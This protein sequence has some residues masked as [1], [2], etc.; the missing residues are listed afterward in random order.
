MGGRGLRGADGPR[1]LPARPE[2]LRR[3]EAGP[4]PRSPPESRGRGGAALLE[5]AGPVLPPHGPIPRRSRAR[6]CHKLKGAP[7]PCQGLHDSL[8]GQPPCVPGAVRAQGG[9]GR[10]GRAAAPAA[11][12]GDAP[13]D[14]SSAARPPLPGKRGLGTRA[15]HRPLGRTLTLWA[16]WVQHPPRR[17]QENALNHARDNYAPEKP[18]PASDV[19]GPLPREPA[20]RTPAGE[21]TSSLT[22][23]RKSPPPPQGEGFRKTALAGVPCLPPLSYRTNGETEA[24]TG[25]DC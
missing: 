8:T 13:A 14:G 5:H 11:S 15:H 2:R 23:R 9:A 6:F 16:P 7:C 22:G 3:R 17:G 12:S 21:V 25:K 18:S 20:R 4:T 10:R 1:G 24:P 19:P